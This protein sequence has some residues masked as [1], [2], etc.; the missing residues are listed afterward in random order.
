VEFGD[1]VDAGPF[2]DEVLMRQCTVLLLNCIDAIVRVSVE[3]MAP[4][5]AALS[6][7]ILSLD[8]C[9]PM[10]VASM[11]HCSMTY[12]LLICCCS[13]LYLSDWLMILVS[14]Y[15]QYAMRCNLFIL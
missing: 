5:T 8:L 14:D 2:E 3:S 12:M 4:V 13:A 7:A 1:N 11:P 9:F 10:C 6:A 15:S